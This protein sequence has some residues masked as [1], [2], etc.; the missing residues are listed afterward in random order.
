MFTECCALTR[1]KSDNINSKP[2]V[3]SPTTIKKHR[4]SFLEVIP[5]LEE[6]D[7]ESND[8]NSQKPFAIRKFQSVGILNIEERW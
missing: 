6:G 2:L 3:L 1:S 4:A 7:F 8:Q 5:A